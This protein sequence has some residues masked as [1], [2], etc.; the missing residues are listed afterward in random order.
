METDL[1]NVFKR[2]VN[3]NLYQIINKTTS[4]LLKENDYAFKLKIPALDNNTI[5]LRLEDMKEQANYLTGG[6]RAAGKDY[7]LAIISSDCVY[8]IEMKRGKKLG[9]QHPNVQLNH[10]EKW[11]KHL[12]EMSS[13]VASHQIT[14]K[15]D[16]YL[17]IPMQQKASKIRRPYSV[18]FFKN[19][20]YVTVE[21]SS[22]TIKEI[23]LHELFK[24]IQSNSEFVKE[25][26]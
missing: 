19:Q 24:Q 6:K 20:A 4:I 13:D 26:W 10:G 21:V 25:L 9:N 12:L 18:Y 1:F 3:A 11:L 17:Y 23:D 7:D 15:V 2:A 5:T 22:P 16:I 14:H 8:Q